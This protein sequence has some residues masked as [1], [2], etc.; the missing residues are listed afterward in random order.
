MRNQMRE[1]GMGWKIRKFARGVQ[2]LVR[3]RFCSR[4]RKLGE[5]L[6]AGGTLRRAK[7]GGWGRGRQAPPHPCIG[8]RQQDFVGKG[9]G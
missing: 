7:A 2:S 3:V 4:G 9:S 1:S 8:A 5:M 6:L